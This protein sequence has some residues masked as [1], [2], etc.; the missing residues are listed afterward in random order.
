M[1]GNILLSMRVP[2]PNLPIALVAAMP[3]LLCPA[4]HPVTQ[5]A[6]AE[7]VDALF[8]DWDTRQARNEAES[9]DRE[10]NHTLMLL[11]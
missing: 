6:R 8:A 7:R 5:D 1:A 2:F 9:N 11:Q 3:F 4:A 10:G